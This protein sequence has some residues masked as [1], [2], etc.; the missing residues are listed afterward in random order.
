[1]LTSLILTDNDTIEVEYKTDLA[2]GASVGPFTIMDIQGLS[3]TEKHLGLDFKQ[4][5]SDIQSFIDFANANGLALIRVDNLGK[6]VIVN[7]TQES[8]SSL[9]W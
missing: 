7:A 9:I 4:V 8:S 5:Q 2:D 3:D 1:M 6:E